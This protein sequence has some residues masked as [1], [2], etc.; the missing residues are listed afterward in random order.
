MQ[1]VTGRF[2]SFRVAIL[3]CFT[4]CT[5][6]PFAEDVGYPKSWDDE[7]VFQQ[8]RDSGMFASKREIL[9]EWDTGEVHDYLELNAFGD[10]LRDT[11]AHNIFGFT[12]AKV[13]SD[14]GSSE[15]YFADHIRQAIIN[16]EV[17]GFNE[18]VRSMTGGNFNNCLRTHMLIL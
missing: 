13:I 7:D 17:R 12:R 2:A 18:Q 11:E 8:K 15:E 16:L 4:L 3:I 6:S 10:C 5:T 14:L 1:T 9:Y